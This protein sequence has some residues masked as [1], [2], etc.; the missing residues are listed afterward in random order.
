MRVYIKNPYDYNEVSLKKIKE[1]NIQLTPTVSA[2]VQDPILNLIGKFLGI[3]SKAD[4]NE[5]YDKIFKLWEWAHKETESSNVNTLIDFL[6]E[7]INSSPQMSP[8]RINDLIVRMKLDQLKKPNQDFN[9]NRKEIYE[10]NN[11]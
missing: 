3:E 4:W 10:Q 11:S 2:I 6:K 1:K 7:K 8:R 5:F 9:G